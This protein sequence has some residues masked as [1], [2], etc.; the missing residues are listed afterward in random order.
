MAE[1]NTKK[2][3]MYDPWGY[4]DEN[5]YQSSEIIMENDLDSFF[6]NAAYNKDDNKIHFTNKD[7]EELV[8]IDVSE[9]D[10]S[11]KIIEKA[12]YEDGK[13]YILFTN[14]DLVTI[15]VEELIDENEFKGGLQVN[16]GVVSILIDPTTEPYVTTSDDGLKVSGI[17]SAIEVAVEAEKTR[18]ESAETALNEKIEAET[19]RAEGVET[20]LQEAINAESQRAQSAETALDEKI[21]AETTRAEGAETAL[22]EKIEAEI[23]RSMSAE[24]ALDAKITQEIADREADVDA[25]EV[26]AKAREDEIEDAL[27]AEKT[28]ATH[29]E[30]ELNHR[31]DLVNDELDSE[32]SRAL[33]AE[34]ELR[35]LLTN[36]IAERKADV[37]A[38]E[39]R[40]ISA[41]T[42]LQGAINTES[43][44]AQDAETAL[45]DK[46]EQEVSDRKSNAVSSVD[47]DESGKTIDF[48]NAN[49]EKIDSID[50]TAFIKDGMI[51]SVELV[52][53]SGDTYLRIT[54]NTDAGKEVTDINIGDIFDSD[55]YYTKD[56]VD[57]IVET[58]KARAMSAETALQEAIDAEEAR[59]ES[60]ETALDEKIT[61]EIADREADVDAEE[62]RAKAREDEIE[63][64]V[65]AEAERAISAE[66]ALQEAIDAEEAR[67]TSAETALDEKIEAETARAESA[68][69]TLQEAIDAEEARATSAETAL[70]E[71]IDDIISGDTPIKQ[72]DELLE[73]LGYKDNDTLVINNPN[74]VAFGKYNVSNTSEDASGQTIF[75]IGN[76]KS[77]ENRSNAFEVRAD[78]TVLMWVEGDFMA[79]NDLLGMLAHETY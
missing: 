12:W 31:I 8:T 9:F 51:D 23:S 72:L 49:N 60:A 74:E 40:A 20:A 21:E 55:S 3:R 63:D 59:A 43:Q 15:D 75:S 68:E 57:A 27:E 11:D 52:E 33:A 14:G 34:Q 38:E 25:E 76:G 39:A 79:V 64:A 30:S 18:A 22:D 45:D 17:D 66:T 41:E 50:A 24:T 13:I 77:D 73:K 29:T 71:R 26:R 69:T 42:A 54:W 2:P 37:D 35:T 56:E 19:T 28:R 36:E 47:Y 78:G 16:D 44:R 48:Y 4:Q 1:N 7:G 70:D 46:I 61:Q 53:L 67:A 32:E 10:K 58:E 5:N 6:V 62:A 65:E